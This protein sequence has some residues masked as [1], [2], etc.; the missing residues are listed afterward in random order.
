MTVRDC[1]QASKG[2]A[3]SL[4]KRVEEAVSAFPVMTVGMLQAFL[5][6]RVS[7]KRRDEVLRDLEREGYIRREVMTFGG[8]CNSKQYQHIVILRQKSLPVRGDA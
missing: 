8:T 5:T 2:V 6:S 1:P 7:S 4:R 3:S